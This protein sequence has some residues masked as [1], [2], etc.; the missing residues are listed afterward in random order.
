MTVNAY[1]DGLLAGHAHRR[2]RRLPSIAAMARE[3]GF[4]ATTL[5]RALKRLQAAGRVE[6]VP[7]GGV[8]LAET[9]AGGSCP[10]PEPTGYRSR[11]R[12]VFDALALEFHQRRYTDNQPIPRVKD[13]C[14]R[15]GAAHTTVSKALSALTRAGILEK[16]RRRYYYLTATASLS[17][18]AIGV[19]TLVPSVALLA[20][21]NARTERF[22]HALEEQLHHRG[23]QYTIHHITNPQ[24]DEGWQDLT[25]RVIARQPA[26]YIGYILLGLRFGSDTGLLCASIRR[27]ARLGR[28]VVVVED[29]GVIDMQPVIASFADNPYVH[30]LTMG[31]STASGE[32]LGRYLLANGHQRVACFSMVDTAVWCRNRARGLELAYERAGLQGA[33][34]RVLLEKY[35]SFKELDRAMARAPAYRAVSRQMQRFHRLPFFQ[36][37]LHEEQVFRHNFEYS[38]WLRFI[39]PDIMALFEKTLRDRTITAWVTVFDMLGLLALNWLK[40]RNIDLP[41]QL[42]LVSMDNISEAFG[43]GLSSFDFDVAAVV[44][45]AVS[46]IVD[47]DPRRR[48]VHQPVEPFGYVSERGTSGPAPRMPGS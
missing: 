48:A 23:L 12:E 31:T 20:R 46:R 24:S 1:L 43:A 10:E 16:R 41:R 34:T 40:Q 45:A 17:H 18:A 36:T 2:Q 21:Y 25:P 33:V 15:F 13:L 47:T 27:L 9:E 22:W 35:R 6:I 19:V 42:S 4:S 7:R 14:G 44:S 5:S 28:P 26:A 37:G 11:W 29:D 30:F 3:G 8:F 39:A 32:K 38:L